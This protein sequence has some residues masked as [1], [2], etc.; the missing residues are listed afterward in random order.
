MGQVASVG[1]GEMT[2]FPNIPG[3]VYISYRSRGAVLGAVSGG[4]S[5]GSF[6]TQ[7]ANHFGMNSLSLGKVTELK[8]SV[9]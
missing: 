2:F 8:P 3:H 7:R 1:L 5:F 6:H 4:L 9:M